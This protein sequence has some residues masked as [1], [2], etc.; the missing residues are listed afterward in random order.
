[1]RIDPLESVERWAQRTPLRAAHRSGSRTLSYASLQERIDAV[2]AYLKAT[3]PGDAGPLLVLGHKDPELLAAFLGCAKAGRAYIPVDDGVPPAR[4][5]RIA[6]LAGASL[7]LTANI[8]AT[9]PPARRP[10]AREPVN[11]ETVQYIIFTSGSTGEPKGVPITRGNLDTFLSWL[12]AEQQ[13]EPGQET[14]LNQAVFS[15]DLSVMDTYASLATGGTLVSLRRDETTEPARLFEALFQ[16][17][18]TVWVSTPSFARLC[19]A[20]PSFAADR[21]PRLH[22]FLFCGE[23]L[24]NETAAELLDRFPGARVFNTY[25]PTEATVATT[26]IEV[27]RALLRRYPALPIGRA[28]PGADVLV[29]D[30]DLHPVPDGQEGELLIVGANVSPG[31]LHRPDLS[32]GAFL[33]FGGRRAYRTG[34]RGVVRDGLLFFLGRRDT[35]VKLNGYRVE[36]GEVEIQLGSLRGVRAAAVVV[37]DRGGHPDALHA[38]VVPAEPLQGA[39]WDRVFSATLRERLAERL[40]AYMLPRRIILVE[41]LPL[42]ANGKVDR[43]RLVTAGR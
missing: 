24:P 42:T 39:P 6:E 17:A 12:L 7:T 43:R 23:A 40:P 41:A 15:F 5:Q 10:V 22:R 9:L 36:P 27:D 34:D 19:L 25:G 18:A 1:M 30:E 4:V 32:A 20:E 21:L 33:G 37:V 31:Y 8:V 14:F 26:S 38:Y 35:Q 13:F 16:S 2:A 28:M 11:D 29:V 3:L